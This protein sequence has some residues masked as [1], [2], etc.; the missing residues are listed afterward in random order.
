MSAELI[1][2]EEAAPLGE[3]VPGMSVNNPGDTLA[4]VVMRHT[5]ATLDLHKNKRIAAEALGISL[6]T[7]Y[8]YLHKW[9]H[10]TDDRKGA[11]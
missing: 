11:A 7:L 6:K 4:T 10:M 1:G 2:S 9:G 3:R 5:L 8:N